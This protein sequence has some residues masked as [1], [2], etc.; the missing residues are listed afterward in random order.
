MVWAQMAGGIVAVAVAAL[1][2]G[3]PSM[4][5]LEV[6]WPVVL[7]AG[8]SAAIAYGGLFMSL[9]T[10]QV[11][12]VSPIISAWCV[13]SVLIM[14]AR[15]EPPALLSGVGV[16]MVV[17]GNV[18]VAR[19][20]RGGDEKATPRSALLWAVLGAC[21]FAV[22][23]PLL[24]AAGARVGRL[25]TVPL[26]WAVELLVLVPLLMRLRLLRVPGERA[27][28]LAI[29]RAAA[30]E[31]GGFICISLGLG[32]AAVSVVSP[33]S[34]LSTMGSVALGVWLL[35]ERVARPALL[36][37]VLASAGVVVVNL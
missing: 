22:M 21:G 6:A 7:G 31:V 15:G 30:F 8:L 11:A 26:V 2:E 10:G 19:S 28:V 25:W 9:G 20:V 32:N 36:G 27:D 14:A 3:A 37:A 5:A 17:V 12:I 23:V 24:D 1:V 29:G 18:V 16:V 35:Q 4:A 13:G 34:S 33:V